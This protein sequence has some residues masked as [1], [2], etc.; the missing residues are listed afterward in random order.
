MPCSGRPCTRL[1]PCI[2]GEGR[3]SHVCRPCKI[4]SR[5]ALFYHRQWPQPREID[6]SRLKDEFTF[7][8]NRIYLAFADWGFQ[9]SYLVC[10]N[11]L[12]IEQVYLDFQALKMPASFPGARRNFS[13]LLTFRLPTGPIFCSPLT[14]APDFLPDARGRMWEGATVTN[15][16]LQLAFHMG[17]SQ[18]ILIGVDHSF[19][20]KGKPNTTVVS[21][22]DDQSHFDPKYFGKG[23]RWQLPD[24]DTSEQGY[25]LARQAYGIRGSFRS[26]CYYWRKVTGFSEGGV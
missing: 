24:L 22:G 16:C 20:A 19:A 13:S 23:F 9:T 7:G 14:P 10:V 3:A 1:R 8:M 21:Q 17:F 2:P 12:V 11:S 5:R 6:V 26:R 15:I 4:I 25:W 18:A